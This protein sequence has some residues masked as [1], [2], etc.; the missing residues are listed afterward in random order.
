MDHEAKLL[1][2]SGGK[3]GPPAPL[4]R[5]ISSDEGEVSDHDEGNPPASP[6]SS[7]SS[8]P[9]YVRPPGFANHGQHIKLKKQDN[10]LKTKKKIKLQSFS[11][12]NIVIATARP[13]PSE[14]GSKKHVAVNKQLNKP[15]RGR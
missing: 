2:G 11:T 14:D 15:K 6:S 1:Y 8:G 5:S 4:S 13:Q 3:R 10:V 7:T 12:G 9:I